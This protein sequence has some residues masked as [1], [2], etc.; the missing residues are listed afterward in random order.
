MYYNNDPYLY[1]VCNIFQLTKL[2]MVNLHYIT[3]YTPISLIN[4]G[5][6]PFDATNAAKSS[7][8]PSFQ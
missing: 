7:F 2:I 6:D 8:F 4:I 5:C 1:I 3:D